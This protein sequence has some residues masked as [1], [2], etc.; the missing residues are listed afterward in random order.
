LRSGQAFLCVDEDW[1][2]IVLDR[3]IEEKDGTKWNCAD[4]ET[5]E[6]AELDAR[7]AVIALNAE[8][9]IH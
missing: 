1:I 6:L 5:G 7:D 8:V 2:G 4:I 9:M 3:T